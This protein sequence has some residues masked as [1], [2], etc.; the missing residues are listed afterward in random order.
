MIHTPVFICSHIFNKSRPIL[1]VI[2]TGGD[3]QML[4]GGMHNADETPKVVGMEHLLQR[5]QSLVQILDLPDEYEAERK[6]LN[7]SWIR[8]KCVSNT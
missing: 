7:D 5:D 8:T 4:C 2:K 6:S 3:W 1:L